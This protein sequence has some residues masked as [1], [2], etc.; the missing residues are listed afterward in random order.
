MKRIF[1]LMLALTLVGCATMGMS[2]EQIAAAGKDNKTTTVCTAIVTPVWKW[3]GVVTITDQSKTTTRA[4]VN[5]DDCS[6]VTGTGGV[7]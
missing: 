5:G 2:P 3:F 1:I 4:A 6:T 7:Q